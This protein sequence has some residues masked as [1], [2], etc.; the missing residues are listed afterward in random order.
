MSDKTRSVFAKTIWV[1]CGISVADY[2]LFGTK[3]GTLSNTLKFDNDP[4]F[5]VSEYAL[6]AAA[7]AAILLLGGFIYSK[8]SKFLKPV[9]LVGVITVFMIG[10]LHFAGICGTYN[11]NRTLAETTDRTPELNLSRNGKNVIVLMLD[12][13]LGA[14]VPYIFNEKPELKEKFSGFTYYPNTISYGIQ[15][16][17]AAPAL[18]GGYEYTPERLNARSDESLADKHDEALK[19]MPD[20][21]SKNGYKVTISDPPYAGYKWIS[22]LS[23]FDPSYTCFKTMGYYNFFDE[24]EGGSSSADMSVRINQLRNRNLFLFSLMKVSPV[25]LQETVYNGGMYNDSSS[26]T[27]SSSGFFVPSVVQKP[28]TLSKSTGFDKGFLDSYTVLSKLDELTKISD[29]NENTFLMMAND[30]THSPCLLQQPGYVPSDKVDNTAY[31]VDM[32]NR[33]TVNGVTMKMTGIAQVSHYHV[34]MAAFIKLSEWF[35]YLREQGVY[36]NTRIILVSDHGRDGD[37]FGINS[38]GKNM[39]GFMPLLMVKDFNAK[40]FSINEEFMTNA[41]TPVLAMEG[42]IKDPVN[43]FTGKPIDSSLKK[44]P[45]KTIYSDVFIEEGNDGNVFLP[46]SWF[47]VEGDPHVA[48]NWKYDGDR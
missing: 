41:D 24:D 30:A 47:T 17:F 27:D 33:Y 32:I 39:E 10:G 23:I 46:G 14:D 1:I 26:G 36:D 28:L 13:A 11:G 12:R 2:M 34:N 8:F 37:Q 35:D 25:I 3:L 45:Q 44:G 19:V 20:L 7:V 40:G 6:N 16:N 15:T 18:Y 4:S 31:D 48:G 5:S 43:P 29:G 38:N 9:L 22:D 42:L 21:F